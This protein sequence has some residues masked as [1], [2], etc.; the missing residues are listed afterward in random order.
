MHERPPAYGEY[1]E[2]QNAKGVD[3]HSMVWL[4]ELLVVEQFRRHVHDRESGLR[5]RH[6]RTAV[7]LFQ[8]GHAEVHNLQQ[9]T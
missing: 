2:H 5:S 6:Q 9:T 8:T 1:S 4:S 3:V 7:A